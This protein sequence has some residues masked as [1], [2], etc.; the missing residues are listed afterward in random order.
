MSDYT[1][2]IEQIRNNFLNGS[3]A[4]KHSTVLKDLLPAAPTASSG[5]WGI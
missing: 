1:Q 2:D 3:T 5:V 4:R